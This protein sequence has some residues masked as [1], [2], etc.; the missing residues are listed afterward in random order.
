MQEDLVL[1]PKILKYLLWRKSVGPEAAVSAP[2]VY[3][4][5]E[6]LEAMGLC[7][8]HCVDILKQF[9]G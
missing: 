4:D 6:E 8:L 5:E 9:V 3:A 1:R 7:H 2:R